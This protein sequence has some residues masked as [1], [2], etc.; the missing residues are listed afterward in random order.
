MKKFVVVG[1]GIAGILSAILLAEDNKEVILIEKEKDLGGLFRSSKLEE[2]V[3]VD[4]GTHLFRGLGPQ[5]VGPS[6][7]PRER[8]GARKKRVPWYS[9]AVRC[10]LERQSVNPGPFTC[11]CDHGHQC[12]TAPWI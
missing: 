6:Y 4:H 2:G 5:R 10:W 11:G 3:W 7:E 1:G 8:A 12:V 9:V